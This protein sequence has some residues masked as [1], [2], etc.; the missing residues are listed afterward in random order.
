M[1]EGARERVEVVGAGAAPAVDR[2]VRVAHRHHGGVAEDGRQE[3][4]LDHRRV[5]VFVEQDD[6]VLLAQIGTH[7]R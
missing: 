6:P 1:G 2:L 7:I 5:L 3:S 4:G